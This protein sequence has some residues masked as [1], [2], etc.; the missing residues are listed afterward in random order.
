MNSS[1]KRTDSG[2]RIIVLGYVIRGPLG[3][4]VWSNL[5]YLQGLAALGHDV[6][7]LEDSDDYPS[8]Y[9][10]V[11]GVTDTDPAYGLGFAARVFERIG[12]G[13]RWA[14]HDAHT[15]RWH[16]PR[17]EDMVTLCTKADLMLNLACVNP[18]RPWLS[19]I[20]VRAYVDEDPA[21]NQIRHLTDPAA[22]ARAAA[23]NVFF[24]FGENIP[25]GDARV[26][27]DGFPWI[28]TRQPV[29]LDSVSVSSGQPAEKFTTIM[30]WESYRA[31]EYQGVRYGM[32]SESFM[33]F[34]DL[35]AHGSATFELA[36]GGGSAPRELLRSKGWQLCDPLEV[37][38]DPWTYEA[39]IQ[40]SKAEFGLAKHGYVISRSG[41]FSERS[42]C[43]L[44][45][46][47]PV[48]AHETGFSRWLQ[49]DAGL[50]P[51]GTME[52]AA[53]GVDQIQTHYDLHSRR[54]RDIAAEY[55]D[56]RKVLPQLIEH[57]MN[58]SSYGGP[59]LR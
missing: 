55:F 12:F 4:M 50:V 45:T 38:L 58:G 11:R 43:Y 34:L 29:L 2:L 10:P 30:Q 5:Q 26:P 15:S 48:L 16:G 19:N 18:L 20:P 41:W 40:Q 7:F 25:T 17:A 47:H 23:H 39:F 33:P 59:A 27:D 53:A 14:F 37:T 13:E 57:A 22:Q 3:G 6:Y 36:L 56:S 8:C 49:A 9:D 21:F 46:G 52:E 31:T 28:A 1:S 24:T 32:K 51:F 35:P 54:A 42:V 44:A